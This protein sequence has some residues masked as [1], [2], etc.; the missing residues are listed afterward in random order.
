M[1]KKATEK[2]KGKK[3]KK[4]LKIV[5][6]GLLGI[7]VVSA[8]GIYGAVGYY[9]Q[10][11]FYSGTIINGVDCSEKSVAYIKSMVKQEA[12]SYSLT[13]QE[14]GGTQDVI[15]SADIQVSYNDDGSID[16]IMEEQNPW[17]WVASIGKD[18]NY[19]VNLDNSYD[20]ESL[21]QAIANM[22]CMKEENMT[23]PADAY[24]KDNGSFYEIVPEVEGNT[25]DLE[26]TKETIKKAV[27]NREK[28]ISLED[29][30]CYVEPAVR[31]DDSKLVQEAEQL[32][33]MTSM[34]IVL[35]FGS[36]Q[37][38]V[39]RA[40]LQG[41]IV[42]NE[43]DGTCSYDEAAVKQYVIDLSA[44]YNTEGKA[45]TFVTTGGNTVN[46]TKGDYGWRLWQDKT[47]ESLL[48]AMK[49]G[50]S[51]T[52]EVTWLY[53]G[54]THEGN[55]INGTYVEISITE[56]RMWFYKNGSLLVDTPVVTGNPNTG[57]GTPAGGVWKLKDKR[58][59][60][61]LTGYKEDGSIDYEEPV[62]YWMPF[63]G[64][65]GIHD[66]TKRAA[67]GG[68]IYLTNGSHGCVN[69]PLEAVATIYN[70]IDINTPVVVY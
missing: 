3:K 45:R 52:V 59:P 21:D 62:N 28:E 26:K 55:E 39:D 54:Q 2:P 43:Q 10:D 7:L 14:R 11:R 8:V 34:E 41:W 48:A 70:N 47:T 42:K 17:F 68:D 13:I 27:D 64:G 29:A 6:I 40:R 33:Q 50:Q 51:T 25:L 1:K 22:A 16:Q 67:F 56:Q 57:H 18:K 19:S 36:G 65:V 58:A 4:V 5:L 12:E 23:A 9:Y 31:R 15:Q 35:D 32:N 46:L 53:K 44:K 63:N 49:A 38:K 20:E 61:T 66:L 24:L 37:E 69:T 30:S 60:F